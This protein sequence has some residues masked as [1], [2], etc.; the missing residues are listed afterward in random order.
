MD[1]VTHGIEGG[2]LYALP[3]YLLLFATGFTGWLFLT[4]MWMLF[5]IGFIEGSA[6]DVFPWLVGRKNEQEGWALYTLYHLNK[7]PQHLEASYPFQLHVACVD[8]PFHKKPDN[9]S[10]A[11]W[12]ANKDGI[13]NWWPRKWPLCIMH[14]ALCIAGL[15]VL[16]V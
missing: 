15:L 10:E 9:V 4:L 2:L 8:P 13:R 1:F 5:A 12:V 7:H 3:F 11:D 14:W 16:V 6:P